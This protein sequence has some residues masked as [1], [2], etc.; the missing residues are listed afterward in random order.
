MILLFFWGKGIALIDTIDIF[1][2]YRLELA[3]TFAKQYGIKWF[4]TNF[5]N[6]TRW[7]YQIVD[8]EYAY[9]LISYGVLYTIFSLVLMVIIM[10]YTVCFRKDKLLI[11]IWCLI[12]IN[13]IVNNGIFNISYNPFIIIMMPAIKNTFQRNNKIKRS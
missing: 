1:L 2:N 11:L 9:S 6:D 5:K 3:F 7:Y 10:N 13:S 8:S 4:G 12:F